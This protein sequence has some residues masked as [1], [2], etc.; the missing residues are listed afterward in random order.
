[1]MKYF[2]MPAD[3]KR[4]TVES[5]DRLN[6]TY[7]GSRVS[8]V[9]GNITLG[10][11]FESGRS[12]DML[13]P[14]DWASLQEYV[15]FLG[16]KNI[17]FNYTLNMSHMG[18]REF[19]RKGMMELVLFLAKLYKAGVRHLTVALP[20]L[21][22]MVKSLPY[23]FKVKASVICQITTANKAAAYKRM[24][25]DRMVADESIVRNFETLKRVREAASG[26][27]EI[28]VNSICFR[29]C[30]YRMFHYNQIST[31]S[32]QVSS[33]ASANYYDHRCLLRRFEGTAGVLRLGWVRPE[34]IKYYT[35]IGINFFKLQGRH[36]VMKGDPA[37]AVEC[38]F[39]ESYDGDLMELFDLFNPTTSF[40]VFIHNRCL[41]G[42]IEPF[43]KNE[44]FCKNDCQ[45]CNHCEAF[46]RKCVDLKEIGESAHRA[47]EFYREYDQFGQLLAAIVN[48]DVN[49]DGKN[50]GGAA[51][52][53]LSADFDLG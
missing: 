35:A 27:V 7:D 30:P 25:V 5:Y 47:S 10:N 51:A 12:V 52:G 31:D 4:E 39:K 24:G 1:M 2:S 50:P 48:V 46:A 45:R 16:Q 20:S 29:D 33:K 13:P 8:E 11:L 53:D 19:S 34:D 23:D 3:F 21:M 22:E 40:R 6:N 15:G 28:I 37:R 44:N 41:D 42:F 26:S 36:T 32:I 38:Y 17:D 49:V 43:Y 18:N 9:Y 14:V